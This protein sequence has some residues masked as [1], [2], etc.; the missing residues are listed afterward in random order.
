MAAEHKIRRGQM[1]EWK[2]RGKRNMTYSVL[3]N[4]P[5]VPIRKIYSYSRAIQKGFPLA[6]RSPF[7]HALWLI[8]SIKFENRRAKLSLIVTGTF[9]YHNL[10]IRVYILDIQCSLNDDSTDNLLTMFCIIYNLQ[11]NFLFSLHD[12]ENTLHCSPWSIFSD[13]G[14][15]VQSTET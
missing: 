9:C 4:V 7:L 8:F 1:M 2:K 3:P 11:L 14:L 15:K 13:Q 6:S 10:P 12:D 5:I